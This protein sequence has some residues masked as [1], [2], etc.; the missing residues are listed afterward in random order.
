[1]YTIA[2]KL[3]DILTKP[4]KDHTPPIPLVDSDGLPDNPA[5]LPNIG[6]VKKL[7]KELYPRKATG[8][9]NISAWTLKNF[10]E[11]L[12]VVAH[13]ILWASISEG[14]YP[15]CINTLSLV[16]FQKFIHQMM[17]RPISDRYLFFPSLVKS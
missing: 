9:D 4:G 17:S 7:L 16:L 6:Q 13:D 10:A 12:A 5:R 11:E 14:K 8:A 15:L 3:Q 2:E 1:M